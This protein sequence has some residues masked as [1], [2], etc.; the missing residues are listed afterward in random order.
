M[1][2]DDECEDVE[3]D[4]SHHRVSSDGSLMS[5]HHSKLEHERHGYCYL[6]FIILTLAV[7]FCYTIKRAQ[8]GHGVDYVQGLDKMYVVDFDMN[9]T[10]S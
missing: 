6:I 10:N 1:L 8:S 4:L 3:S 9:I 2:A 5:H 7:K